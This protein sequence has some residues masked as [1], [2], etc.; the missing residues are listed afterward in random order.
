MTILEKGNRSTVAPLVDSDLPTEE[1]GVGPNSR[2]RLKCQAW[3]LVNATN[4]CQSHCG[5]ILRSP[6]HR[7]ATPHRMCYRDTPTGGTELRSRL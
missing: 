7:A 2:S 4:Q 5:K 6:N 1:T 3:A